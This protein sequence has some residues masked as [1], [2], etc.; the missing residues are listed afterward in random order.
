LKVTRLNVGL[1]SGTTLFAGL[2]VLAA[3]VIGYFRM[4]RM[5][6]GLNRT[7]QELLDRVNQ[8]EQ[9]NDRKSAFLAHV[10]HELRTPLNGVLG[11]T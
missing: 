4:R 10:S 2:F 1:R 9:A 6:A 3:L 7:C 8:A 5:V 11:M